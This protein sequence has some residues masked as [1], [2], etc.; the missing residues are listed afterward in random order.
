MMCSLYPGLGKRM[1]D[2][3]AR[4]NSL[5]RMFPTDMS[6]MLLRRGAQCRPDRTHGG[7]STVLLPARP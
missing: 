4:H 1:D 5:I 2:R 3:C 6:L 7:C